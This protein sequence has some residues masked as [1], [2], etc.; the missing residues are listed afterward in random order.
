[1]SRF[2]VSHDLPN[3]YHESFRK[4]NDAMGSELSQ[5]DPSK[6]KSEG[7]APIVAINLG[8]VA[9]G[10]MIASKRKQENKSV[11]IHFTEH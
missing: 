3:Q 6:E 1:M 7:K 8:P 2:N 9:K 4:A 5:N 10:A 11:I